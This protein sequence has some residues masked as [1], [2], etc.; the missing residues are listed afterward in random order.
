MKM[1]IPAPNSRTARPAKMPPKIAP[2]L[3]FFFEPPPPE[4]DGAEDGVAGGGTTTV[5]FGTL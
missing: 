3:D 1:A 5:L 2:V 4:P